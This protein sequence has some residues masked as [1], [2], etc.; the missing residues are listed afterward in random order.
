MECVNPPRFAVVPESS[1][2]TVAPRLL[3]L[4]CGQRFHTAWTNLDLVPA[5]P[6]IRR[7]DVAQPLPFEDAVF[8]AVYHSHLLEHLP[9]AQ[10]LPFLCECRRV[11]KPGGI[12][13]LAIPN[14]EAI[15][16]L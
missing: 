1:R 3:N 7:F 12:L 8:D 2:P 15:A 13:R 9:R 6:S 16:R 10:A 4:G 14:L 11:L 5:H